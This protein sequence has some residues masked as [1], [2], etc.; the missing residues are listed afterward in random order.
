MTTEQAKIH[1]DSEQEGS[2]ERRYVRTN[3]NIPVYYELVDRDNPDKEVPAVDWELLFDDLEPSPEENPKL[4]E[5]LFDINQKINMLI[6]HMQEKT[7]FNV[8]EAREVNISGGGLRFYCSDSFK[9][10]D[11]LILKTFLPTHAHVIRIRCDIVRSQELSDG[12]NE[13]AV[14]YV[15]MD[16]STRDKI[17][18]YIFAKQRRLLRSEKSTDQEQQ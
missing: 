17:I 15:E 16:E 14:K 18:R 8:P 12:R 3:D 7:G 9:V 1:G 5:L 10:G 2:E 13:I 11:Q 6:N 4:Y